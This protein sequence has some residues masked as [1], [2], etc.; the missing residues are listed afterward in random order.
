M[1]TVLRETIGQTLLLI[2][3]LSAIPLLT[4]MAVGFTVSVLQAATQIQEQTL[5]FVPRVI[6]VV[7]VA[8]IAWPYL[9]GELAAFS[10]Q[11]LQNVQHLSRL[12]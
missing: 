3:L 4:S 2:F 7:S 12:P 9:A 5:S 10:E 11:V 6:A 1:E 8:Y